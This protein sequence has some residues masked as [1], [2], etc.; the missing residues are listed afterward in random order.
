MPYAC[1]LPPLHACAFKTSPVLQHN[2]HCS[3]HPLSV[4]PLQFYSELGMPAQARLLLEQAEAQGA[5]GAGGV[6][7]TLRG[8]MGGTV[9]S[10]VSRMQQ[11][12]SGGAIR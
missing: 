11:Q 10:L 1:P 8:A 3:P 2:P 7:G 5:G 6:L 12:S 9:G 4:A